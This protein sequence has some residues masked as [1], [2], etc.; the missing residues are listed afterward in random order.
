MCD[1]KIYNINTLN[2]G[3]STMWIFKAC[4]N[5]RMI[6]VYEKYQETDLQRFGQISNQLLASRG[7]QSLSIS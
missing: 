5:T 6:G 7:L 4:Q 1:I 3:Y 2:Y